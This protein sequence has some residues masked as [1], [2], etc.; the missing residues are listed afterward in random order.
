MIMK[1][2]CVDRDKVCGMGLRC[3]NNDIVRG[4]ESDLFFYLGIF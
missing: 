4:E 3:G 2:K 1:I